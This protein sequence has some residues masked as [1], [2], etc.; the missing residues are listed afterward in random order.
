LGERALVQRLLQA[1]EGIT[2]LV[3]R[4][5]S[6]AAV[7]AIRTST[8]RIDAAGIDRAAKRLEDDFK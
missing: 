8:E 3:T 5:L 2:G 6:L 1:S 7:E 4:M